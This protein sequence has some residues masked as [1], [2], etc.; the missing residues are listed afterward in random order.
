VD[1]DGYGGLELAR[2]TL[3]AVVMTPATTKPDRGRMT[4]ERRGALIAWAREPAAR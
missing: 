3:D 1:A 2:P 4:A